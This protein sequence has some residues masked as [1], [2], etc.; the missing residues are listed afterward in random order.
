[1]KNILVTGGAGFIGSNLVRMLV[2]D[3]GCQVTVLDNMFTGSYRNLQELGIAH[4]IEFVKGSVLDKNLLHEISQ[5]KDTVFHLAVVNIIASME[6]PRMDLET[7][8]I[9]TFNVLEASLKA[10]IKR[11]IYAST[12][13]VYGNVSYTPVAEDAK[14]KFLNFYCA[15]KYSGE[16]YADVFNELYGLPV[17]KIRYSNV[18]GYNQRPDNPYAGVI[19]KFS[20]WALKN[21]P[22]RIF[23]DGCQTRDFTFI[24]DACKATILAAI[25][26]NAI[27]KTYNVGTGK[28]TTINDLARLII[29]IID[30]KS[31]ILYEKKRSIDNIHRRVLNIEKIRKDLNFSPEWLLSR[32]LIETISW[33]TKG[34]SS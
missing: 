25:C 20:S 16:S 12:S 5:K 14:V 28:E 34:N 13:S 30:S 24:D 32:G 6:N 33:V 19:A 31:T 10:G 15:S 22:L 7:N 26:P 2:E 1:M 29:N 18:Y 9:G 4:K 8:I 23:G 27:G 17:T 21:K 3:Y 11:V